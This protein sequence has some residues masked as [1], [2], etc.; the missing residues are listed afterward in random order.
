MLRLAVAGVGPGEHALA[1]RTRIRASATSL[2]STLTAPFSLCS[3]GL[4][5]RRLSKNPETADDQNERGEEK[6]IA[7]AVVCHI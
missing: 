4:C 6:S 2:S 7:R 1:R 3:T 5:R